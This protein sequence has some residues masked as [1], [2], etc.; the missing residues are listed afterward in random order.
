MY[1]Q[2][3]LLVR[4]AVLPYAVY[5]RLLRRP[6]SR[7]SLMLHPAITNVKVRSLY[8]GRKSANEHAVLLTNYRK[9]YTCL[10][11]GFP[12]AIQLTRASA[13]S[14]TRKNLLLKCLTLEN[15]SVVLLESR[16]GLF[17]K[18]LR[19]VQVSF[20]FFLYIPAYVHTCSYLCRIVMLSYR[21]PLWV[22]N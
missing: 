11:S 16:V 6:L 17:I 15:E 19:N 9:F 22:L 18:W 5:K 12:L 10:V 4:S 13:P 3:P 14:N 7:L 2:S 1:C 8:G 21:C 20:F